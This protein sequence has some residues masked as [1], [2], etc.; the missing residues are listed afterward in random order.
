[1]EFSRQE[2]W[3]GEPFPAMGDLPNPRIK[4]G[5]PALKADSLPPEPPE[6]PTPILLTGE[7]GIKAVRNSPQVLELHGCVTLA[8]V[9]QTGAHCPGLP[10]S[11]A[12]PPHLL[13]PPRPSTSF[14]SPFFHKLELCV[15]ASWLPADCTSLATPWVSLASPLIIF[16]PLCTSSLEHQPNSSWPL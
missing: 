5:S 13:V 16:T 14:S 6:Q 8:P 12:L 3:N 4:L 9:P 15:K 10:L 1:M 11:A 7:T 2:Y